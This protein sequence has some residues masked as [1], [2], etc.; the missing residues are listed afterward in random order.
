[1]QRISSLPLLPLLPTRCGVCRSVGSSPCR[2]CRKV[3]IEHPSVDVHRP[4]GC[5]SITAPFAYTGEVRELVKSVKYRHNPRG[6]SY[7]AGQIAVVMAADIA[8]DIDCVTWA[9]TSIQRQ[10]KRGFDQAE[11]LA[12]YVGLLLGVPVRPTL[13][14]RAGVTGQTGHTRQQRAARSDGSL[15]APLFVP[16]VPPVFAPFSRPEVA[17]SRLMI[18]DDVV[19]TGATLRA[20]TTVLLE[21]GAERVHA[22]VA[23]ATP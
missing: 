15:F 23:A 19:T 3:L 12:G 18:V 22:A 14:H 10:R 7:F 6:L 16:L 1:V 2:E 4:F 13:T 17:G 9:P 11:V 21:M 5:A 8:S 20:A